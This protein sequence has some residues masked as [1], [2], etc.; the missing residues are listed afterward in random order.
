MQL[1]SY[2]RC[3]QCKAYAMLNCFWYNGE[4]TAPDYLCDE[5]MEDFDQAME[6]SAYYTLHGVERTRE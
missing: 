3:Q 1:R 5:C 4:S 6:D 2:G